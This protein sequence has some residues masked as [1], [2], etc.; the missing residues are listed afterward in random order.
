MLSTRHFIFVMIDIASTFVPVSCQRVFQVNQKYNPSY[1][2]YSRH[3]IQLTMRML[4]RNMNF[5]NKNL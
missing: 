2:K 5:Y 3:L 4:I 1:N